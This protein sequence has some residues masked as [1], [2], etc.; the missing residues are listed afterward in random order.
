MLYYIIEDRLSHATL[1][2]SQNLLL[3][4]ELKYYSAL[5]NEQKELGF[6]FSKERHN[7][8]NQLLAI[9]S[10]AI[11]NDNAQIIEFINSLL[12]KPE[13]GILS[14]TVLVCK[15]ILLN[16]LFNAKTLLAEQYNIKY[17]LDID[18][19]ANLP[20]DNIDLCNFIGNALDNCFDACIQDKNFT[21]KYVYA[22]MKFRNDI[23]FCSFTNSCYHDLK[24]FKGHQFVTTKTRIF[25]H[26]YGLSSIKFVITKYNGILDTQKHTH[27]F[28]LTAILYPHES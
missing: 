27:E 24:M 18:V 16:T 5:F 8:K 3:S 14:T 1:L 17:V 28:S 6:S 19:P 23:L 26:G 7:L 12:L 13:H 20:F 4:K 22:T 9:R 15:N 25:H 11:Q 2:I 21:N 10:Y